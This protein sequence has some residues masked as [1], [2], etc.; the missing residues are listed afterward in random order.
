MKKSLVLILAL[1]LVF[2]CSACSNDSNTSAAMPSS[3]PSYNGEFSYRNEASGDMKEAPTLDFAPEEM[4]ESEVYLQEDAK[5]IRRAGITME[6]LDFDT[7][8]ASLNSLIAQCN[9]YYGSSDVYSASVNSNRTGS[10]VVRVPAEKYSLFMSA[11]GDV[12]QVTRRNES[13][14]DVGEQYYD[15]ELRLETLRTKHER[16]MHLLSTADT[17]ENIVYLEST[18]A[19]VEY[20]I[21]RLSGT[22]RRYDGLIDYA[23]IEITLYERVVLTPEQNERDSFGAR[24]AAAFVRGCSNFGE[25]LQDLAIFLAYNFIDLVFLLAVVVAALVVVRKVRRAQKEKAKRKA[26][27]EQSE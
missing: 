23:T 15:A 4:A 12:G 8:T 2:S 9:G 27:K 25:G 16:L 7:A 26:E 5:L 21:D 14:E 1:V 22:L 11:I 20:E 24:F 6:T 13:T 18:L 19:D 17:L 10:Y 3:A